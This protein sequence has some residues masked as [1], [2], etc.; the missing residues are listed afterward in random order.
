MTYGEIDNI[1]KGFEGYETISI[2]D[3]STF[4][5]IAIRYIDQKFWED[6]FFDYVELNKKEVGAIDG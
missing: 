1:L 4:I 2:N 5:W 3:K 6:A